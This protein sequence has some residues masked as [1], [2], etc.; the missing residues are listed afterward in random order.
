MKNTLVSIIV[1]CYNQAHFLNESLASVLNQTYIHWECIIVNDGSP[2]NTKEVA[3]NWCETD[4]RFRYI[5]KE[6][7]GLSSARNAGINNSIGDFILPLDADDIIDKAFLTKLV[8]E[9][10]NNPS[11]AIITCYSKFFSG[12]LN[13]IIHELKP[14]GTT[15]HAILFENSIIATSLYRKKCW[16]EV[17]GYDESMKKG[18]E[19]WEFWISILKRNWTYKVV[20]EFLFYYRKSK[21]SMLVDTLQNHRI[22]N[23]EYVFN[24]HQEIYKDKFENTM[25]YMFY[26]LNLFQSKNNKLEA[27][28]E[29]KLGKKILNPLKNLKKK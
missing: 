12:K 17:G 22:S 3:K 26:L 9:L 13:N 4:K 11:I 6:N 7:G 25:K 29:Y 23:M 28:K 2:D 21:K 14:I 18:F 15:Y 24:K 19:D 20:E 1:P 27:S 16:D 8:P 5:E 10:E